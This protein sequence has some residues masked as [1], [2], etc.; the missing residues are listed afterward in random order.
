MS[1]KSK[2]TTKTSETTKK[3]SVSQAEKKNIPQT[4][5]SF[6]EQSLFLQRTAGNQAVQRILQG[7][8][9]RD[10]GSEVSVQ[11]TGIGIQAKLRIGQS[12]DKYEHKADRIAEHVTHTPETQ[13][14]RTSACGEKAG[15]D[16]ERRNFLQKLPALH[17]LPEPHTEP[18]TVPPVVYDVMRSPGQPLDKDTQSFMESR[19]GHDFSRVR[20][21]ADVKAAE[22]ARTVNA[23]AFTVGHDVVFGTGQY[24]PDTNEGKSLLAHELTHVTQQYTATAA[25]MS[26][27]T[28]EVSSPYTSSEHEA[29]RIANG[30]MSAPV[31]T[32][33]FIREEIP[34]GQLQRQEQGESGGWWQGI[35]EFFRR[36]PKTEEEALK[37]LN[38]GLER[39]Q[40]V[41]EL[42]SI[43]ISDPKV[44]ER[45]KQAVEILGSITKVI[46]TALNLVSVAKDI[47][48]F[49]DAI[50]MLE[51]LDI[52]KD[53]EKAAMAFGQLFAS[54]GKLCGRLGGPLSGYCEWLANAKDFFLK[55]YPKV[56]VEEITKRRYEQMGGKV[57]NL[58]K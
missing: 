7:S 21:H 37:Q 27:D 6:V 2:I 38:E 30:V 53:Q 20:V 26:D 56:N 44:V 55:M 17:T 40:K 54:L 29:K 32:K 18:T 35:K 34:A 43:F 31:N 12:N 19:F 33:A 24:A 14:Q 46:G 42:G 41:C 28:L 50:E 52:R 48:E 36:G 5:G 3:G 57:E 49:I 58:F 16:T 13:L 8:G 25:V 51:K 47:V 4:P 1:E 11:G 39:A 15:L 22:S 45:L 9:V 10:Q 23:R